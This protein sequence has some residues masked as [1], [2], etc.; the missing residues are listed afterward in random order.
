[1]RLWVKASIAGAC[2]LLAGV[3][4]LA[5]TSAYFVF[6]HLER[7]TV[8][9]AQTQP[10]FEAIRKRFGARPPLVEIVDPLAADIRIN[11]L[12]DPDGRRV[13]TMHVLAWDAE[14]EQLLRTEAPIWLFRFSALNVLSHLQIS[15]AKFRLTVVDIKRYGP[16]VVVDF[17]RPGRS[18]VLIW[19]D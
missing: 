1:M 2:L 11:K 15:P 16:G 6:R 3:L 19:V 18:R 9:E 5:G 10:E 8:T 14:E 13:T 12:A 4:A 17:S 7:R